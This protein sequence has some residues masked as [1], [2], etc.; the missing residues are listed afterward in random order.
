MAKMTSAAAAR[1]QSATC[2]SNGGMTPKGTFGARAQ[3]A[4]AKNGK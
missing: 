1:I 3:A 2:K 4:A